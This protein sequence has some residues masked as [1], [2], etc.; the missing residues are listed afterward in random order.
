MMIIDEACTL[1]RE[2]R[3]LT[4]GAEQ[5][6]AVEKVLDKLAMKLFEID[7]EMTTLAYGDD[8]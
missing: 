2:I 7:I 3:Q 4:K 8:D 1:I 6:E 5:E